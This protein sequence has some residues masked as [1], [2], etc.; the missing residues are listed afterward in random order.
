MKNIVL[1]A[2][3][4]VSGL[5]AVPAE[6]SSKLNL[7]TP[8]PIARAGSFDYTVVSVKLLTQPVLNPM[9]GDAN[10]Y[11]TSITGPAV[12]QNASSK[13]LWI[14]SSD[15]LVSPILSMGVDA[16][17]NNSIVTGGLNDAAA[18]PDPVALG[19]PYISLKAEQSVIL[20][21]VGVLAADKG[22][23]VTISAAGLDIARRMQ[24]S[25]GSEDWTILL[26]NAGEMLNKP[27]SEVPDFN[28]S[29]SAS[30]I[31]QPALATVPENAKILVITI[32]LKEWCGFTFGQGSFLSSDDSGFVY[33]VTG[34]RITDKWNGSLLRES[35]SFISP[36]VQGFPGAI[37]PRD[38]KALILNTTKNGLVC[39]LA[40]SQDRTLYLF[41]NGAD[42]FA[43]A[44]L[45]AARRGAIIQVKL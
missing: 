38:V 36:E 24:Q 19:L 35:L 41:L 16:E 30:Q 45:S 33:N 5:E 43:L 1:F 9:S 37:I 31:E 8:A 39:L 7:P 15:G 26:K 34:G 13:G 28:V 2:M 29:P 12:V 4:C 20:S 32:P 6:A 17:G 10:I 25:L 27:A 23:F 40:L 44:Q 3:L 21:Q 22:G 18:T 14:L 42:A 11:T